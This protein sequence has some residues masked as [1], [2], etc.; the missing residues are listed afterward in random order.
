MNGEVRTF[1]RALLRH[2]DSH[3]RALPWRS[4][5]T[6]YRVMVSEF[7]LQQTRAETVVPY[8]GRWLARFPGWAEL[9]D[10]PLDD[11]LRAWKGLGYYARAR[12]L[13]RTAEVVRERYGGRLPRD[14]DALAELPGVGE[15]TAGAVA[16]IAFGSVVPAVDGNVRRVLC[17]LFDLE[18]PTA[19][20][21]P[22]HTRARPSP[23]PPAPDASTAP[24]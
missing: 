8:Y 5:R 3:R 4:E 21:E 20:P 15:Y 24:A 6:P 11:V 12:N 2:F 23:F 14:P 19:A 7:M 9:A 22:L 13:H 18:A 17:R 1:R 10:A 16:S